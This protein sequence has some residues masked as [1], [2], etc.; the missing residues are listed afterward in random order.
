[1][2]VWEKNNTMYGIKA[3]M[4]QTIF[5]NV[6]VLMWNHHKHGTWILEFR[7]WIFMIYVDLI[8]SLTFWTHFGKNNFLTC[9]I[10]FSY[11]LFPFC[12]LGKI[13]N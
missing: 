8:T 13:I 11:F 10:F 7:C 6:G 2:L 12:M 9:F 4:L 1:M 5:L 3:S